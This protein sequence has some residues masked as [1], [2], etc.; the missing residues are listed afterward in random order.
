[1]THPNKVKNMK[2]DLFSP[3]IHKFLIG[4]TIEKE[5]ELKLIKRRDGIFENGNSH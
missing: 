5:T 1:M 4:K 3:V 2:L